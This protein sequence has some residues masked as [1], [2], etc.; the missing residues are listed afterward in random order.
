M[1][2]P[3]SYKKNVWKEIGSTVLEIGKWALVLW[4]LWPLRD[5]SAGSFQFARVVLGILLFVIFT[6]K[7][8]YD[9]LYKGMLRRRRESRKKDIV[10]FL[11]MI[12]G[13][14][15]VVGLVLVMV[16]MLIVQYVQSTD[17]I[18]GQ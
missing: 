1:S 13:I 16:A 6:G 7:L 8:F 4:C 12:A 11:G 17:H 14:S 18:R 15:L 3:K 5:V 9:I 2:S 10:A